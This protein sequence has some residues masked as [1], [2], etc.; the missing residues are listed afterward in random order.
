[1]TQPQLLENC[2]PFV[3]VLLDSSKSS[4]NEASA[5]EANP[6]GAFVVKGIIQKANEKN[7]NGR[8]YPKAILEREAVKYTENFVRSRRAMG[9]LDH[10]SCLHE[11][12]L[13]ITKDGWKPIKNTVVGELVATLNLETNALEY[14]PI[15]EVKVSPYRGK[16]IALKGKNIDTLTTPNHTFVLKNRRGEFVKKSAQEIFELAQKK[17]N[18]HLSIP[19]TAESWEGTHYDTF[20]IPG[21]KPEEFNENSHSDFIEKHSKDLVLNAS[22]FFSFLGFYLSEGYSAPVDDKSN[23]G[24]FL[25]QN[26]GEIANEFRKIIS[27]LSPELKWNERTEERVNKHVMFST[28]DARLWNYVHKLGNSYTKYIPDE[29]KNASANLLQNLFD[30]FLNGDGTVV[31]EYE[32]ASIFS[33]SKKLIEDFYEVVLKLGMTGVI[34]EQTNKDDYLFAGRL[35]EVKNK[36]PLYRLWIKESKAIHL[37]FR[38]IKVEEIDFNDNVYCLTV[39]NGNFYCMDNNKPFW[40]GNSNQEGSTVVNLKNVSHIIT[41]MHWEGNNLVG[42]VEILSTPSGNILKE[43]FKHNV[44]VGISSRGVGSVKKNMS[45]GTDEVQDDYSLIAFDFVSDPS[46]RGAFLYPTNKL[47]ESADK[48]ATSSEKNKWEHAENIIHD[49]LCELK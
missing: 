32:R 38:F 34:K 3:P 36:V 26:E 28:Y 10:P 42:T 45:E 23:Y 9:E 16:M 4:M 44:T 5:T 33:V 49:I 2:I 39:K 14:N 18:P 12:A 6:N 29:I 43:L 8:E 35:I 25:S 19:I 7:Q 46:T 47:Q 41:E 37:D 21:L 17:S 48:N 30:W 11:R 1:M 24:V 13:V 22:A 20:V 40:T 31:T 15:E 27:N